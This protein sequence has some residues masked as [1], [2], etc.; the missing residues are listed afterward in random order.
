[1]KIGGAVVI[2][3][4]FPGDSIALSS[5]SVVQPQE[6]YPKKENKSKERR[7]KN[8]N[9]KKTEIFIIELNKRDHPPPTSSTHHHHRHLFFII[10]IYQV[11]G[12]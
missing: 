6:L 5:Y 1:L 4:V 2:G 8:K 7:R 11:F 12:F 3:S 9:V 10:F